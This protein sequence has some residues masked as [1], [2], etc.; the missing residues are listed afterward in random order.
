MS[1]N[2]R[3]N[4]WGFQEDKLIYDERKKRFV[5]TEE[6]PRHLARQ[7]RNNTFKHVSNCMC[8]SK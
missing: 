6:M 7:Y 4:F 5:H 8:D 3:I 1:I 2:S